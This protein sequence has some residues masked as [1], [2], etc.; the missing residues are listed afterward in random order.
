[1]NEKVRCPYCFD[2]F[3]SEDTLVHVEICSE[4]YLFCCQNN[5]N[6]LL[7]SFMDKFKEELLDHLIEAGNEIKKKLLNE[8]ACRI[9]DNNG[10]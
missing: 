4:L 1:M 7:N 8:I 10:K 2:N 9:G 6:D 3:P 5:S